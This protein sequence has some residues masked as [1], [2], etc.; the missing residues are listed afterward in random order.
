MINIKN[1]GNNPSRN[2]KISFSR[3]EEIKEHYKELKARV[4]H[5]DKKPTEKIK[6]KPDNAGDATFDL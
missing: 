5:K 2:Q 1:P 6:E 4:I 3:Y